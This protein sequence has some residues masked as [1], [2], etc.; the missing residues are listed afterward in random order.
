MADEYRHRNSDSLKL[1][2]AIL[3]EIEDD[4]DDFF[5][6]IDEVGSSNTKFTPPTST[7]VNQ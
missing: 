7:A 4:G 1:C 2:N 3:C 5:G 6:I